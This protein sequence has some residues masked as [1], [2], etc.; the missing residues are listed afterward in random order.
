MALNSVQSQ[1]ESYLSLTMQRQTVLASNMANVDTP[2]YK[3]KDIDFQS[4]MT[5]AMA[6]PDGRAVEASSQAV[7]GLMERPDG[8]NVDIDRE[9]VLMAETQLQYQLGTQ[10]LKGNF[11]TLLAAINSGS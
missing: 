2:G 6:S 5:R 4:E 8:N 7:S 3:T 1:L 11:H 9:S 10:L